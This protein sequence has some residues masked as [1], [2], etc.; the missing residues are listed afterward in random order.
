MLTQRCVNTHDDR[1]NPLDVTA[2]RDA[3]AHLGAAVSIVTS[4]GPEGRV[5]FTA[6]AIC[7]V[8]DTPPTLLV[9]LN[10]S[11]SAHDAVLGNGQLCVNVLGEG[12]DQLALA[13]GGKTAM[14][15]RF[16]TAEWSQAENGCPMLDA[17]PLA[18][19]CRI[20]RTLTEGTHDILIC[21]VEAIYVQEGQLS[22]LHYYGRNFHILN[23]ECR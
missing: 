6:T 2:F 13:F 16:K 11:A 9:C 8:T 4:D 19:S 5:G 21:P 20:K 23:S 22:G 15:S 7:S 10:Q 14:E 18:L 17:V 1:P 12:H 3:M